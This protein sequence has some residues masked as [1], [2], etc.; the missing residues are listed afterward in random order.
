MGSLSQLLVMSLK[1]GEYIG[2]ETHTGTEKIILV[3]EYMV[4]AALDGQECKPEDGSAIV[5][6]VESK[7]IVMTTYS[8]E[9][10]ELYTIYTL[11]E[12]PNNTKRKRKAEA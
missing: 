1:P 8:T 5:I 11:R 2:N 10:L 7:Y 6:P 3:Q 12:H 4:K 9:A